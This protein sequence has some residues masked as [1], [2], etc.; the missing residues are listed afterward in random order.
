MVTVAVDGDDGVNDNMTAVAAAVYVPHSDAV[1]LAVH[2]H[3]VVP[4]CSTEPRLLMT[5]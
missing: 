2:E 1:V 5:V 3:W 4:G